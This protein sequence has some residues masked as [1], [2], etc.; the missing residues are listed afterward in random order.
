[1]G[2]PVAIG[3]AT[4]YLP[5]APTHSVKRISA[6]TPAAGSTTNEALHPQAEI[7]DT[8]TKKAIL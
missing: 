8:K 1:M 7:H 6:A 3:N 5:F 4:I 2:G